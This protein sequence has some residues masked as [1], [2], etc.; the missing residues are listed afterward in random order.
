MGHVFAVAQSS[1]RI[2]QILGNIQTL[3][4]VKEKNLLSPFTNVYILSD[5]SISWLLYPGDHVIN[6]PENTRQ[7]K[8]AWC[9]MIPIGRSCEYVT[10]TGLKWNLGNYF[11]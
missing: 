7:H 5:D 8:K 2:D 4:L 10:S 11:E 9:S 1:G 3:F 6:I